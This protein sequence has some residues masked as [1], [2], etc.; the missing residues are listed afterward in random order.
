MQCMQSSSQLMSTVYAVIFWSILYVSAIFQKSCFPQMSG[1]GYHQLF[2]M[3]LQ[4]V[5]KL[6]DEEPGSSSVPKAKAKPGTKEKAKAG[7]KAKPKAKTGSSKTTPKD[8]PAPSTPTANAKPPATPKATAS[9]KPMKRPS[10][11][12]TPKGNA[13]G[14]KRP[15]SSEAPKLKVYTYQYPTGVYG[16]KVNGKQVLTATRQKIKGLWQLTRWDMIWGEISIVSIHAM[17]NFPR[18]KHINMFNQFFHRS[19]EEHPWPLRWSPRSHRRTQAQSWEVINLKF[20]KSHDVTSWCHV[21]ILYLL[22]WDIWLDCPQSWFWNTFDEPR[23][24]WKLK[25]FVRMAM[26]MLVEH[27]RHDCNLIY[28][29]SHSVVFRT[30]ILYH[31]YI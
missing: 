13:K 9:P 8:E 22:F 1:R 31:I 12:A 7:P 16:Y 17:P 27:C 25:W 18:I 29:I 2:A 21:I 19:V 3:V 5:D 28:I 20:G 15:A 14:K 30:Y 6:S 24:L 26:Q 23:L 4:S 11:S 10:A